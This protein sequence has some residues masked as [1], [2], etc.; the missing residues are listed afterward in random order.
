MKGG[1]ECKH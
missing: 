1:E